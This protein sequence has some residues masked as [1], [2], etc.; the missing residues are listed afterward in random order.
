MTRLFVAI[1]LPGEVK[2]RLAALCFGVSG[3]RWVAENN[4]H[5]TLRF[6]GE[7]DN[8]QIDDIDHALARVRAPVCDLSLDGV[9]Q[10]ESRRQPRVLWVGT[11]ANDALTRLHDTV[12]S[13][14]VR[15]GLEPEGRKFSAHITLAR[16]REARRAKVADFIAEHSLFQAGPFPVTSFALFSSFLARNGAI[17]RIENEYP[18]LPE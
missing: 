11:P 5:L 4:L 9:G 2:C 8:T 18:L 15:A 10:F 14:L 16:L 6:I 1:E 7:V 17:H 13:A 3:A 12:E